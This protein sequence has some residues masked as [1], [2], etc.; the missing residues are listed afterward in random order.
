MITPSNVTRV[1]VST[2][3]SRHDPDSGTT[4]FEF[5]RENDTWIMGPWHSS[6]LG[7]ASLSQRPRLLTL[8]RNGVVPTELQSWERLMYFLKL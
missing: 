7:P 8:W 6:G 1:I 4:E 2:A 5:L 3:E